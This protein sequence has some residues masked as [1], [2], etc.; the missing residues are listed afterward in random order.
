M[1]DPFAK[2]AADVL[3]RPPSKPAPTPPSPTQ[4]SAQATS[5]Q[6]S[7]SSVSASSSMSIDDTER[8][9]SEVEKAEQI[10]S[11]T[12]QQRMRNMQLESQ[13]LAQAKRELDAMGFDHRKDIDVLRQK[14]EVNSRDLSY[15][16]VTLRQKIEEHKAAAL[17]VEQLNKSKDMLTEHLRV[18]IYD[19]E[20][21]KKKK[22]TEIMTRIGKSESSNSAAMSSTVPTTSMSSSNAT[23]L[24]KTPPKAARTSS[25]TG[26]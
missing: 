19:N 3:S 16:N 2:L 7:S 23:M 24:N 10:L 11:S 21:K 20:K 17:E 15:A 25:W 9:K 1:A 14:I 12:L 4:A 18:I 13:R 22:L 6:S 8:L 26:F 5:Q